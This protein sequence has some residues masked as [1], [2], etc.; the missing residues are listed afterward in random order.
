ML[1]EGHPTNNSYLPTS[2]AFVQL[3][4]IGTPRFLESSPMLPQAHASFK[5]FY[6]KSNYRSKFS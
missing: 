5:L 4:T 1:V 2:D 3:D 6:I